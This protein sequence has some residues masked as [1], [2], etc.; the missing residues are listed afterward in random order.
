[1]EPDKNGVQLSAAE[2]EAIVKVASDTA[3][4]KYKK[5]HDR[6]RE[7]RRKQVLNNTKILLKNYRRFKEMTMN[8]VY[9]REASVNDTLAEILDIMHGIDRSDDCEVTSIKNKVARTSLI[10]EHIDSM[11][12]VYR[13]NCSR[14]IEGERRYRVVYAMFLSDEP[15]NTE[16]IAEEE[17]VAER[18]VFRDIRIAYEELSVLFF[19]IDGV[20]HVDP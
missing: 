7:K 12:E 14:S 6:E 11:L 17:H 15:M 16:R 5:E 10:L 8:G 4:E 13:K 9:G 19:G 18:T 1:M 20:R 3:I 2:L